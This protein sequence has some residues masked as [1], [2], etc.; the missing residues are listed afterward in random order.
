MPLITRNLAAVKHIRFASCASAHS[1]A[2]VGKSLFFDKLMQGQDQI[3]IVCLPDKQNASV[4]FRPK[5]KQNGSAA[6]TKV[7]DHTT[8]FSSFSPTSTSDLLWAP[9]DIRVTSKPPDMDGRY[10]FNRKITDEKE[11][12]MG[13]TIC[14]ASRIGKVGLVGPKKLEAGW[15]KLG[16]YEREFVDVGVEKV[17]EEDGGAKWMDKS[18]TAEKSDVVPDLL[19]S[20]MTSSSLSSSSTLSSWSWTS[21]GARGAAAAE[22]AIVHAP[23]AAE[24]N[25][26]ELA[27]VFSQKNRQQ[28]TTAQAQEHVCKQLLAW[29]SQSTLYTYDKWE[30]RIVSRYRHNLTFLKKFRKELYEPAG[31][32]ISYPWRNMSVC[33]LIINNHIRCLQVRARRGDMKRGAAYIVDLRNHNLRNIRIGSDGSV[34]GYIDQPVD[35]LKERI[36]GK[37]GVDDKLKESVDGAGSGGENI[38]GS[39]IG[40][41][42]MEVVVHKLLKQQCDDVINAYESNIERA[43]MDIAEETKRHRTMIDKFLVPILDDDENKVQGAFVFPKEVF[44]DRPYYRQVYVYPPWVQIEGEREIDEKARAEQKKQMKYWIDAPSAICRAVGEVKGSIAGGKGVS[45]VDR[46]RLEKYANEYPEVYRKKFKEVFM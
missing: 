34:L 12:I 5:S 20:Q 14:V 19:S 33:N 26:T 40:D 21:T 13:A 27:Q 39:S 32:T 10:W 46:E 18:E 36:L 23:L 43:K 7:D 38:G 17:V 28:Q 3:E 35:Q 41:E 42:D 37:E 30:D 8:P 11:T 15:K 6:T 9:L 16:I 2:E 31:V 25:S 29:W 45:E 24:K 1:R 4:L 22:A 44:V